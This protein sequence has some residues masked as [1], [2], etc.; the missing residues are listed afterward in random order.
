MPIKSV[1]M[2]ILKNKKMRF[3]LMSQGP[4]NQKIRF[5]GQK[6]CPVGCW[7][8]DGHT[9]WLLWAPFQGFMIFPSTYVG[10]TTCIN[11]IL[12]HTAHPVFC[13]TLPLCTMSSRKTTLKKTMWQPWQTWFESLASTAWP[14]HCCPRRTVLC[15]VS[16]A[17]AAVSSSTERG[18]YTW[19]MCS[20]KKSF[21]K[22]FSDE[23]LY[24]CVF[25]NF[26]M[27]HWPN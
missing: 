6:V 11:Q 10:P 12:M 9:E 8:T 5:L 27:W 20:W 19:F 17:R 4:L 25:F 1:K 26:E 7:H 23:T 13:L 22:H 14:T 2:K 15:R 16:T 3:F 24:A 21:W 18:G